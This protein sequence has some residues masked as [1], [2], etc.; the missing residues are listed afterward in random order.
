MRF[1]FGNSLEDRALRFAS[2]AHSG[3]TDKGG[4]AYIEHAI[5][6]ADIV[7]GNSVSSALI[8]CAYLHDVVEDTDV[9]LDEIRSRFGYS[10]AE[11]VDRLTRRKDEAYFDYIDRC[12]RDNF[13]RLIKMADLIDNMNLARLPTLTADDARRQKKYADALLKLISIEEE[14]QNGRIPDR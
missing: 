3:Q 14:I 5:R 11:T 4:G 7:G 8:A 6:V 9:T 12:G 2:E 13:A 1:S 10:V